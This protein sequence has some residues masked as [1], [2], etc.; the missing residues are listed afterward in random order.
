MWCE[1]LE[2]MTEKDDDPIIDMLRECE[3]TLNEL[4][5]KQK[6][7]EVG[8]KPFADLAAKVRAEIER[9][10]GADRRNEVRQTP[11]R[12]EKVTQSY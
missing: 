4:K 10:A 3:K 2:A 11:E 6:L 5:E 8:L 7:A 12:R 1:E 9:R